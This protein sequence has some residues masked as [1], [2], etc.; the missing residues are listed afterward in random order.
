MKKFNII[1]FIA[2]AALATSYLMDDSPNT[3]KSSTPTTSTSSNRSALS[4]DSYALRATDNT[5]PIIDTEQSSVDDELGT[6]NYYL[7]FDGSGSMN[8]T[9][10]SGND[11]KINVAK[12]SVIEFISKI[13]G[14]ANIGLLIFDNRGVVERA[15]LGGSTKENAITEISQVISGGGTPLKSS[16]EHAYKALSKQATKQ[17]GYGEYHLVVVTDG[18]AGKGED[19][20]YIVKEIISK[21]PVVLHTIGF[22]IDDEHSLNQT[23]LTLYKAANNPQEL[24]MGLDSVLAEVSDFNVD[25][26][27]GQGQ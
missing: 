8:Y 14:D 16:I 13:P 24:I 21:S 17:L 25:S 18:E 7:V 1:V 23:G 4:V 12:K 5:W 9:K 19:P 20:R 10:C 3:N 22:C 11:E 26:F 6:K 2:I 15:V 27:E